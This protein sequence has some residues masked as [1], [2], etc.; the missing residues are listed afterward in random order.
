M[1]S[2]SGEKFEKIANE[3][4]VSVFPIFNMVIAFN[5]MF[6][7]MLG[8]NVRLF[9]KIENDA[10]EY[11]QKPSTW[12]AAHFILVK[13]VKKDP[14]YLR[15]M[16]PK[17]L[18]SG[19]EQI[20]FAQNLTKNISKKSSRSLINGYKKYIQLNIRTYSLGLILPLLDFQLATFLSDELKDILKRKEAKQHF[21]LLTTPLQD[22]FNKQQEVKLLN[23]YQEIKKNEKLVQRFRNM[24]SHE[25]I[26]LLKKR[27]KKIWQLLNNHTRKYGWTIYVYEGPSADHIFFIDIIK[28]FIRRK[29]DPK[30]AL[31]EHYREKKKLELEQKE[32]IRKIKTSNYEKQIIYLARD[33]VFIKPYRRE[34]QGWSYYIMEAW[35]A[36]IAKRT[37]LT[38]KQ[39]RNM[40]PDEIEQ[41]LLMNKIN[42][43]E[44]NERIKYVVCLYQN[45]IK[46]L[47]G[48]RAKTFTKTNTKP[49]R[50]AR[51]INKLIGSV[52]YKGKVTGIVRLINMPGEMEKMKKGDILV[53]AATSPNLM[54][55]IIQAAA[56]VTNE[57]G[58]TCHA[59]IVSREL[60]IPCV[61]GTKIATQVL[62]D[63]DK[64]EVDANKG[65][66][67]K[68]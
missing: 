24:E 29:I 22:T 9:I 27:Y 58:L 32:I 36:E 48:K 6:K 46:L 5:K 17:M 41:A 20:K 56:L 43:K 11:F 38:I 44:I 59:A 65:T 18:A 53:S 61:V 13:K 30:K 47:T 4:V 2:K 37:H 62:K 23:V 63:G 67:R 40:L 21:N 7:K 39:V 19:F 55:A 52:D 28:D 26:P 16:Y 64:V 51:K 25:L 45:K 10:I 3:Y 68:I 14:S 35:F 60:K 12:K 54:P 50:K 8:K 33:G 31:S 1:A 15:K 66:V 49:E 57:G 34:L 42:I